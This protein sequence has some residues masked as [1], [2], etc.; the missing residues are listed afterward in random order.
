MSRHIGYIYNISYNAAEELK[1]ARMEYDNMKRSGLQPYLNYALLDLGRALLNNNLCDESLKSACQLTDSAK[2]HQDPYLAYLALQLKVSALTLQENVDDGLNAAAMLCANEFAES[3]DSLKLA[4]LTAYAGHPEDAMELIS[5]LPGT[6]AETELHV[7]YNNAIRDKNYKDAIEYSTQINRLTEENIKTSM[8]LN[9]SGTLADY[10]EMSQRADNA[11]IKA[12]RTMIWFMTL[13]IVI[14]LG[15]IALTITIIYRRQRRRITDKIL[16]AEQLRDSL[17]RSKTLLDES[18]FQLYEKDKQ[19]NEKITLIAEKNRLIDSNSRELN[20]KKRLLEQN[21]RELDEKKRLIAQNNRELEEKKKLIEQ[22][23]RDLHEMER[24]IDEK[25][26]Q[27]NEKDALLL[28][29][30]LNIE[31]FLYKTRILMTSKYKLLDKL[32]MEAYKCE[33]SKN[34]ELKIAD[35]ITEIIKDLTVSE[36]GL[37]NLENELNVHY[38]NLMRDFRRDLP[39]LKAVD[40]LLYM[41]SV[42]KFSMPVISIFLKEDRIDSIYERKRRLKGHIRKLTPDKINRYLT[43]LN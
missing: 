40:Y 9:L 19:L 16:L 11:E 20:E 14:I 2:T 22:N 39:R 4:L 18:Y 27:I 28:K 32:S 8:N 12:S 30:N 26:R 35:T 43:Y 3:G 1:Y 21:S 24:L 7:R 29:S 37:K 36:D 10:F 33:C 5:R 42:L 34:A 6:D 38:D 25:N 15:L 17:S 13:S 23:D 41:F 31:E